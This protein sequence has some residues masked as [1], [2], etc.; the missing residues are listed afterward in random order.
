[1]DT[2]NKR[3]YGKWA[4]NTNGTPAVQGK[5]KESIRGDFWSFNQ[6][7]NNAKKDGYCLMHHPDKVKARR[8]KQDAKWEMEREISQRPYKKRLLYWETLTK[9]ANGGI[10]DPV[11]YA[12]MVLGASHEEVDRLLDD[13]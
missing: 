5:C 13:K 3:V 9:I 12:K 1:M 11:G 8:D 2:E 4:G 6:C 7:T 10:N